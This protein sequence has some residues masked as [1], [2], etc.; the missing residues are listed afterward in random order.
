VKFAH[1]LEKHVYAGLELRR[2]CASE[3]QF[4]M[5]YR[6]TPELKKKVG[7]DD[8]SGHVPSRSTSFSMS[9]SYADA[10]AWEQHGPWLNIL[11]VGW[12]KISI[13]LIIGS[14]SAIACFQQSR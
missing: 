8:L 4:P 10:K 2:F 1:S 9:L 6:V 5:A 11:A 7:I 13:T 12:R 14:M 3:Q